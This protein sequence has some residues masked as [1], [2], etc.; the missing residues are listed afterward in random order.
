[1]L[2]K[3]VRSSARSRRDLRGFVALRSGWWQ[4]APVV[5]ALF[6]LPAHAQYRTSI[7]G[8]VTDTTGALVPGATLTLT[9]TG[10]NEVR[11]QTSDGSGI[12]NFNALPPDTF[13]LNVTMKGFQKKVLNEL[14]LIPEQPNAINVQLVIGNDSETVTVNASTE[15]A[16][17]TETA[18]SGQ[19][20]SENEIQHMPAFERDV[21]SLIRLAPGVLADGSQQG[22]GGGFL[23]PGTQTGASSNG[24]GNLGA[25][26][27][28][29][30]TENGASAN[31]NGGQFENNGYT[32]DGISTA[33]AVWGGATVITPSEDSISNVKI[34]TNAYDA[35][36]G[37]FDGALTEITTK[38]GTNDLH[39]SLFAQIVRPGLNAYQRW[40]GEQSVV[41]VRSMGKAHPGRTWPAQ[42]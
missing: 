17:D 13:T 21:T 18:N 2:G 26:S 29:F 23:A 39:G 38:S 42:V 30:A 33:S 25:T 24:G 14:K 7:Q 41:S 28:I 36:N 6:A 1:M 8:V 32:V 34:V 11:V 5:L 10:T 20:I 15:S 4:L 22:G 12:Y 31:A 3:A 35:E 37:R 19:T 27:S 16:L 9:D 40:N